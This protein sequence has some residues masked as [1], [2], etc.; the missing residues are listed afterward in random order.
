MDVWIRSQDR[1]ILC[2]VECVELMHDD[3]EYA[4]I[5]LN[6]QFPDLIAGAYEKE[7]ALEVL[8]EI[9][10]LIKKSS[11]VMLHSSINK[12]E[13]ENAFDVTPVATYIPSEP[14]IIY[15]INQQY[16]VYE[17]PQE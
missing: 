17:M 15:P 14:S 12:K 7:R 13:I 9:Q 10:S 3:P 6:G 1:E 8:D 4:K 5:F 2:K 16:L 11:R